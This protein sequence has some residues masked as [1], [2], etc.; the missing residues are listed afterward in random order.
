[1][2][3]ECEKHGCDLVGHQFSEGGMK[4]PQC[5][6]DA[7]IERLRSALG[8]LVV[9]GQTW[10]D[11]IGNLTG[12]VDGFLV[13]ERARN[14]L[15][16]VGAEASGSPSASLLGENLD[17]TG[18]FTARTNPAVCTCGPNEACSNCSP[19][20]NQTGDRAHA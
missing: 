18:E 12:S 16:A 1:M 13:L 15:S 5:D 4:C 2:S 7:E 20:T 10:H 19:V 14:T 6:L 8:E 9:W 17:A 3:A 11:V